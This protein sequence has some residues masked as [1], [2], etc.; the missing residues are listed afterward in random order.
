MRPTDARFTRWAVWGLDS[1]RNFSIERVGTYPWRGFARFVMQLHKLIAG[2]AWIDEIEPPI[3]V[4]R[5]R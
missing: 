5:V 2:D 4:A 3:P 1:R